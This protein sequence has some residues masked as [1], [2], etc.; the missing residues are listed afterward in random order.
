[1]TSSAVPRA[2]CHAPL[3]RTPRRAAVLA[4]NLDVS[5]EQR[6]HAPFAEDPFAIDVFASGAKIMP[7]RCSRGIRCTRWCAR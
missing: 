1:M 7:V 3:A 5:P 2:W 6:R 4:L